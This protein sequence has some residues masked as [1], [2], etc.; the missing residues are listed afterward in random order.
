M[1]IP[2]SLTPPMTLPVHRSL[3]S[4]ADFTSSLSKWSSFVR[5]NLNVRWLTFACV[6]IAVIWFGDL[7]SHGLGRSERFLHPWDTNTVASHLHR[8]STVPPPPTKEEQDIWEPRKNEV[9]NALKHAWTGYKSLAYP[10]DELLPVSG[11]RS[12]K[13]F[14]LSFLPFG[15]LTLF[16]YKGIVA[17]V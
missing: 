3:P 10:S 5:K 16:F 11:G 13:F 15:P 9:R 17:G 8:P 12:D 6:V 4:D 1:D 14:S 7:W 2:P